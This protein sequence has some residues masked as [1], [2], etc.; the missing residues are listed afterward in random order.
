MI[1]EAR[2]QRLVMDPPS[3]RRDVQAHAHGRGSSGRDQ[4]MASQ[5][6]QHEARRAG[7]Y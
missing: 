6:A 2:Q 7:L 3:S 1:A 4:A 5:L